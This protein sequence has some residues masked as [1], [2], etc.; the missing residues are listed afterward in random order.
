M[1][2]YLEEE[3]AETVTPL[4][5]LPM[6]IT[7]REDRPNLLF[8]AVEAVEGSERAEEAVVFIVDAGGEKQGVR[9]SGSRVI[10]ESERPQAVDGHK[11]II[12]I[13]QEADEFVGEAIECG[14]PT[15]TEISDEDAVAEL[16]Q[17][18]AGPHGAPGSAEP[19][20]MLEVAD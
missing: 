19:I 4:P 3:T 5:F 18:A 8:V 2:L 20:A 11:R 17:I 16:A 12:G 6:R 13:L 14:N 1:T 7:R 15:P 9:R 10:S